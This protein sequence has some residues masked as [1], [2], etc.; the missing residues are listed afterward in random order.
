MRASKRV[1]TYNKIIIIRL[2]PL[3]IMSLIQAYDANGHNKIIITYTE[4][5]FIQ[6]HSNLRIASSTVL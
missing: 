3:M 5:T 6:A 1:I 4:R 2:Q